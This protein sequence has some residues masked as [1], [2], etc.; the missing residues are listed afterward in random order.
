M[1]EPSA[2][3]QT[4]T[5]DLRILPLLSALSARPAAIGSEQTA[6]RRYAVHP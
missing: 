5:A 6:R 3:H 1:A 4:A 2:S